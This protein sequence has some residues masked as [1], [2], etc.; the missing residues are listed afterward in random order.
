[1]ESTIVRGNQFSIT[2]R[3]M[4]SEVYIIWVENTGHMTGLSKDQ[5][6]TLRATQSGLRFDPAS[7]PYTFGGY[8]FQG[9]NGRT[10]KE[11]V[12][13]SPV[14]GTLYYGRVSL[15]STGSRTIGWQTTSDT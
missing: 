15:S 8:Q 10:V 12:P 2:L 1:S 7:G 6:P 9:G 4:P 11:D 5:P 14:N 13:L 3:G